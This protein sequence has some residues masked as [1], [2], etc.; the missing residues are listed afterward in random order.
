[1][2]VRSS[3]IAELLEIFCRAPK[4]NPTS[5]RPSETKIKSGFIMFL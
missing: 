1:M 3:L 2:S 4:S 5:C